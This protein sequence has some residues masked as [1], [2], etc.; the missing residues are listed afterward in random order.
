[1]MKEELVDKGWGRMELLLNEHMPVQKKRR[2]APFFWMAGIVMAALLVFGISY[3]SS[4]KIDSTTKND[5]IV[6]ST[7]DAINNPATT[8]GNSNG[9]VSESTSAKLFV[10]S[11]NATKLKSSSKAQVK[12]NTSSQKTHQPKVGN[13]P[14]VSNST[15]H[16]TTIHEYTNSNIPSVI[17]ENGEIDNSTNTQQNKLDALTGEI[18]NPISKIKKQENPTQPAENS[19]ATSENN[20][21]ESAKL[22]QKENINDAVVLEQPEIVNV[23]GEKMADAEVLEAVTTPSKQKMGFGVYTIGALAS[24][25]NDL[26]FGIELIHPISQKINLTTGLEYGH[27][28][29]HD[30]SRPADQAS[31]SSTTFSNSL[32]FSNYLAEN[33]VK[34]ASFISNTSTVYLPISVEYELTDR[35]QLTIGF[36]PG[37]QFNQSLSYNPIAE[38]ETTTDR[39]PAIEDGDL[40]AND[41]FYQKSIGVA[42]ANIGLQYN[43]GNH[44]FVG[45]QYIH[46]FSDI[47][48][49][50]IYA[51]ADQL[52]EI[53]A[54]SVDRN[55]YSISNRS[56][57]PRFIGLRLG[58]RF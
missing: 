44:I 29:F 36:K 24:N 37:V 56:Y 45:A 7:Q 19:A 16:S 14:A 1:M 13:T 15:Q 5:I 49:G 28:F 40:T 31:I 22:S 25:S 53:Q 2:L 55:F 9:D 30:Y 21:S 57:Q 38:T 52:E 20:S 50:V 54:G 35:F 32:S 8:H 4:D 41:F 33:D 58:Y 51:N 27:S 11:D 17:N 23:D 18:A 47:N 3:L 12:S 42:S 39:N 43:F 26:L 6:S 34:S 48:R 46:S 10:S